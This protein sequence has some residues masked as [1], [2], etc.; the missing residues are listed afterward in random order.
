[1]PLTFSPATNLFHYEPTPEQVKGELEGDRMRL[2]IV[3]RVKARWE[4]KRI[5]LVEHRKKK[6]K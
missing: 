6:K 2:E 4:A 5:D 3:N 1:M